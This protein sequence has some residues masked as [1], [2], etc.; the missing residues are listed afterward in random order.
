VD[1]PYLT[2]LLS[3]RGL[4]VV[5]GAEVA[6]LSNYLLNNVWTFKDRKIHGVGQHLSKFAQFNLGSVGSV[7]IQYITMQVSLAL[8]GLFTLFSLMGITVMSDDIYL[9]VGVLIGMVWNFT[10]YSKLIWRKK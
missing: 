9:G 10:V 6:I 1:V 2:T 3:D 8:F 5:L 4:A 7:V